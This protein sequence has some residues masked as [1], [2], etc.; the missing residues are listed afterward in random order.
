MGERIAESGFEIFAVT[1]DKGI[2]AWA[3]DASGLFRA[4]A[5]GLW[6]L[7][8]DPDGVARVREERVAVEAG[9]RETLLVAWLNE[10]LYLHEVRALAGADVAVHAVSDTVLT[11]SVWGETLDPVRHQVVGHVKAVTY[12]DLSV[13]QNPRGWEAR[14][15]VDV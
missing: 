15:V 3:P 5:L 11:A 14:V 1:A 2:R 12:H 9:D 6:S 7:M 8:V 10:L 13:V 4:A